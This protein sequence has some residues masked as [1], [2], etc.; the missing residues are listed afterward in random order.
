MPP[1]YSKDIRSRLIARVEAGDSRREAAR[2]FAVSHSTAVNW[3]ARFRATGNCVAKP[4]GGSVSPLEKHAD[5]LLRLVAEQPD[6]TLDE[7][8]SAMRE[9]GIP[10]SRTALRRFFARHDIT[11]GKKLARSATAA[12]ALGVGTPALDT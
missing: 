7:V 2:R 11:L 4:R 12:R 9:R 1:A 10:G 3:L 5:S 6:L 8:M